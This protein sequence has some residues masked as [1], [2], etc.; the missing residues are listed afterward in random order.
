MNED[1]PPSRRGNHFATAIAGTV[2][3]GIALRATYA[4][5]IGRHLKFGFDSIWYLLMGGQLASGYGYVDPTALI[6][7]G[8]GLPTANF[9]PLYPGLIA[10][11]HHLGLGTPYRIQFAS[12]AIGGVTIALTG[13]LGRRVAGPRVGVLAAL[14]AACWPPLIA[15]DE[16]LMSENL[17]LPLVL[18]A[19][20]AVI[21][22]QQ[23]GGWQRWVLAGV[24]LGLGVL[25]RSELPILAGCLLLVAVLTGGPGR[26]RRLYGALATAAVVA[27][28]MLPWTIDRVS[29]VGSQAV[30]AT[31]GPKTLA[32]ANCGSTYYGGDLG[33]WDDSC[34]KAAEHGELAEPIQ[35]KLARAAAVHYV[36][37]HASRV[38]LVIAARELRLFGVWSPHVLYA[39]EVEESRNAGWQRAAWWITILTLPL[40]A[41]GCVLLWRRCPVAVAPLFAVVLVA[42]VTWGDQRF[43]LMAEPTLLIAMTLTICRLEGLLRKRAQGADGSWRRAP[44]RAAG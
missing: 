1:H 18:W 11:F 27:A 25:T 42:A 38:P 32:G 14:L 33:G 31:N 15:A 17:A 41:F 8:R 26:L 4:I 16:S 10:I 30:L 6:T 20:L 12:A 19:V 5:L 23:R 34:V 39:D 43:R 2:V 13:L 21:N 24:P 7:T 28:F 29:A 3:L 9:P 35:T 40:A 36:R 44:A 37:A 22:A